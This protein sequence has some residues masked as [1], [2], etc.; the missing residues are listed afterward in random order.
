MKQNTDYINM[1]LINGLAGS[2]SPLQYPS[3]LRSLI[4]TIYPN[5][6]FS[7]FKKLDLINIINDT[8]LGRYNGEEVIKYMLFKKFINKNVVA[9]PELKVNNSIV[10]FV[11]INGKS[12]SFEIKSNL[13]N[14]NK[15]PKQINDY[16]KVFEY[17]YVIVDEKHLKKIQE[18]LPD[19]YGIWQCQGLKKK[20]IKEAKLNNELDPYLQLNL[21]N[22]RDLTSYF[23]GFEDSKLSIIQ[24]FS[25]EHIN[26]CMKKMLKERFSS[27][28]D[29]IKF[30]KN[31]IL[32]IDYEFFFRNNIS[33]NLIYG[34]N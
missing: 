7:D 11:A 17:N 32:P 10:D 6:N 31:D 29:F 5:V 20:I 19:N 12:S 21:F 4:G 24:N 33:P 8:L 30:H 25:S 14:L 15:L 1:E 13:D 2:Y 26:L 16:I 27:K 9:A 18:L 3:Q 28:W 22:K 23:K 34:V